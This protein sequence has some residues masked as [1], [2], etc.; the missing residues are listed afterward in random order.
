MFDSVT[1]LYFKVGSHGLLLLVNTIKL[2]LS[3]CVG[4]LELSNL[5]LLVIELDFHVMNTSL[6]YSNIFVKHFFLSRFC[7]GPFFQLSNLDQVFRNFLLVFILK[8]LNFLLILL[9][10]LFL[11][12]MSFIA[13]LFNNSFN[14]TIA[15][16]YHI[17]FHLSLHFNMLVLNSLQHR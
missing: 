12:R 1:K 14:F 8:H 3:F 5:V 15:F 6:N 7:L 11:R 2:I 10:Q 13:K 9:K 4:T 16:P 17:F